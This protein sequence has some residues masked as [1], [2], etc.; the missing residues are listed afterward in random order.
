MFNSRHSWLP[1]WLAPAGPRPAGRSPRRNV[2]L[3]L[4]WFEDRTVPATFTVN[5]LTD[6]GISTGTS[7]DLRYCITQS[8][9]TPGPNI[10]DASGETGTITLLSALPAISQSVEIDGPSLAADGSPR[11][12]VTRRTTGI[13]PLF[14]RIFTINSSSSLQVNFQNLN[15]Y[16]GYAY[17]GG[18]AGT[19]NDSDGGGV[20]FVAGSGT[21]GNSLTFANCYL[22]N[23]TAEAIQSSGASAYGGAV[24][25]S[26][27][28]LTISGST[29]SGNTAKG[30][31]GTTAA[32]YAFGGAMYCSGGSVTISTST[33]GD[34]AGSSTILGNSAVAQADTG[35]TTGNAYGGATCTENATLTIN[36]STISGNS[37][38]GSSSYHGGNA[39]G[40]GIFHYG[41]TAA[42]TRV[43]ISYNVA[44][45]G[46]GGLSTAGNVPVTINAI[47]GLADGGG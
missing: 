3:K 32:G 20:L 4:E 44:E 18:I 9:A 6:T 41:L 16:R 26:N 45:A 46:S 22:Q 42:L 8:N 19:G 31:I 2:R 28:A 10:I 25:T 12:T 15:I 30:A 39:Y 24:Y 37:A 36:D 29:V 35:T 7:G 40:G 17:G 1:K 5:A 43:N 38:I 11:L 13:P 23:N 21:T 34:V 33:I 27:V 14:I 47:G